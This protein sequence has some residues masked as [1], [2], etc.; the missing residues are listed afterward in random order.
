MT[1]LGLLRDLLILFGLGVVVVVAVDRL[2]IPPIVGF[3][4]TGVLGGPHGFGL[5]RG[6]DEVDALAEIGVVLLLFTVGIEFSMQ[7][8]LRM[9]SFLFVGGGLQMGLTLIATAG[10]AR[11]AGIDWSV[12]L[13]L[14]MLVALSSTAIVLRLLAER[15]ET[16]APHGRGAVGIL[17]FQDL[18]VVPLVLVTPFLAGEGESS[19][20]LLPVLL[21]AGVFLLAA[22]VAAR[23][24]VPRL[25]GIVVAT[26][27]REVFL[28]AIVLICL[29]T[30]Y[31]SAQVGLSL[32]LG[33]F[34][35]GLIISESEYSHQALGEVLPLREVFNSLFFLSIGML[36]DVGAVLDR[37]L[38]ALAALGGVVLLKA[39]IAVGVL[40]ALGQSLRVA[41]LTGLVLA[42]I[43][44]FSFVLSKVGVAEGLLDDALEQLFLAVAVG[45][46][47]LTP[48]LQAAGPRLAAWLERVAPPSWRSRG[49]RDLGGDAG[50]V[51]RLRD[52]VIIV[53]YGLN[54]RNLARVLARQS[55]PF[56]V[57]ELNP[58]VVR[59]ERTRGRP[60][61]YGDATRREILTHVGLEHARVL[62]IAISDAA[63]TRCIVAITRQLDP[64]VNII[65]RTRYVAEI[66][67]LLALGTTEVVPEEF[68]TSVEIF[69]RV[70]RR[71]LVPRPAIEQAIQEI[72]RDAYD[73]LRGV[74]ESTASPAEI[75]R[76]V[77]D[78]SLETFRVAPSSTL[79]GR[80]L[81][82]AELR[83]RGG[84]TAVAIR[85]A[86]GDV[87]VNPTGS[88]RLRAGDAV[89]V[90]GRPEQIATAGVYFESASA[91]VQ[92]T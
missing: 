38:L 71:Y 28:L 56:V 39:A 59:A 91:T 2:R 64:N 82:D 57:V 30:A 18:C 15:G 76:Y 68:E 33:A 69:S 90:I 52:H 88:E 66:G 40:L 9:R 75:A 87:V 29:G 7:Q 54:G 3:L 79:D 8:L 21:K 45:S 61:V 81:G 62:V 37:P 23:I 77:G 36:F 78:L 51:E 11:M 32:A 31:I 6:V 26:R 42:Q 58:D 35:A 55:I 19:P 50:H 65:V 25:L 17:I 10:I 49:H 84:V 22:L 20:A 72:R 86:D 48:L 44:E 14:G 70:L 1:D 47:M 43:G 85:R 41:L 4:I 34:L 73:A 5:I 24:V 12:A 83:E 13:F 80:S 53:G 92:H 46:M 67:P 63:A 74:T 60:I 27:K 89:T 16:D